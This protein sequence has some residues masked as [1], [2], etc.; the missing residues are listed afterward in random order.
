MTA[1][2]VDGSP[3]SILNDLG[4]GTYSF[5]ITDSRDCTRDS[6]F[7]LTAPPELFFDCGAVDETL[8]ALNNGKLG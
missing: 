3:N 6:T 4:P 1:P 5:V 7:T 8:A 2:G